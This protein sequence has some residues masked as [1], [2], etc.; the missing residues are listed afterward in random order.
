MGT[1]GK[2]Q[3]WRIKLRWKVYLVFVNLLKD[4]K[5]AIATWIRHEDGR[6]KP[7][8]RWKL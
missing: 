5:R 1:D 2:L 6:I 3:N 4:R 7:V 8:W